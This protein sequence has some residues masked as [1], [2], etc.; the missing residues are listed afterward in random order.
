MNKENMKKTQESFNKFFANNYAEAAVI[1]SMR[2]RLIDYGVSM[3]RRELAANML[4]R[5]KLEKFIAP[6]PEKDPIDNSKKVI[7]AQQ[8]KHAL[9][10]IL[11]TPD[12]KPI[13]EK[14]IG[15][16]IDFNLYK[17]HWG[18]CIY[19][20]K[21]MLSWPESSHLKEFAK[22][23]NYEP[24]SYAGLGDYAKAK[25]VIVDDNQYQKDLK[26]ANEKDKIYSIT[27]VQVTGDINKDADNIANKLE[28]I[29]L[30]L[31]GEKAASPA[32][33]DSAIT[34]PE[35]KP[36]GEDHW[37]K[38]CDDYRSRHLLDAPTKIKTFLEIA[39]IQS[40]EVYISKILEFFL[41]AN[42]HHPFGNIFVRSFHN[43]YRAKKDQDKNKEQESSKHVKVEQTHTEYTTENNKRIDIL[44]ETDSYVLAIENK[45]YAGLQNDLEDYNETATDVAKEDGKDVVCVVLAPFAMSKDD[46]QKLDN[47]EHFVF[48]TYEELFNEVIKHFNEVDVYHK[49]KHF[50]YMQLFYDLFRTIKN[51]TYGDGQ[52]QVFADFIG[53]KN[54]AYWARQA[55]HRCIDYKNNVLE[56]VKKEVKVK[57]KNVSQ[58]S[59]FHW[60]GEVKKAIYIGST[61]YASANQKY[62]PT[63]I[64][65]YD[66]PEHKINKDTIT[67][68]ID[69]GF[70]YS[71]GNWQMDY[72]FRGK[73]YSL[74]NLENIKE[75]MR[76]HK[77]D[78]LDAGDAADADQRYR[79]KLHP[80]PTKEATEKL[81]TDLLIDSICKLKGSKNP[82]T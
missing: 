68:T 72:F 7:Q 29:I 53:Q 26:D 41:N 14:L 75:F 62:M 40:R 59:L 58:G 21:A 51:F 50:L 2:N 73:E 36:K 79:I 76:D 28:E 11:V 27:S 52:E 23:N 15:I 45:I 44:V 5:P 10:Y 69:I 22:N 70:D 66:T 71:T 8:F 49:N 47:D 61:D 55:I 3:V 39:G 37:K 74:K 19:S 24:L 78:V 56:N 4:E 17:L 18:I 48:I 54:N 16:E 42:E 77:F 1:D 30:K 46:Q 57:L 32:I 43:L 13:G 31:L 60:Y 6:L 20:K 12:K 34:D 64:L 65:A 9:S 63:H 33:T 82:T 35:P 67:F 81:I 25:G 38:L 80:Q